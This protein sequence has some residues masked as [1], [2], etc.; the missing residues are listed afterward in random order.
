MDVEKEIKAAKRLRLW[1]LIIAA[2][3][4]V[5]ILASLLLSIYSYADLHGGERVK[6]LIDTIFSHTQFPVLSTIWK[7]AAIPN[8][9]EPL[10]LQNF[11]FVG[12]IVVFFVGAAMVGTA[13]RTLTALAKASDEATQEHRKEQFRKKQQEKLKEQERE[14]EKDKDLS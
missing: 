4:I 5:F 8:T 3:G 10:Q 1:G 7:I 11:W 6:S 2:V 12:E 13:T 14:K 9:V